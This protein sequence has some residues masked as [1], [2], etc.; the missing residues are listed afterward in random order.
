[1]EPQSFLGDLIARAR[2]AGADA[3][4]AVLFEGASLSLAQRLG[5]IEKLERSESYDLGLRVFIGKRQASVS[6][7]ERD[8]ARVGELVERAVAMAH[9]VPASR[10]AATSSSASSTLSANGFSHITG[11]PASSEASTSSRCAKGGE[12]IAMASS[13]QPSI[14]AWTLVKECGIL[15]SAAIVFALDGEA[16]ATTSKCWFASNAGRWAL[17]PKPAPLI[18]MRYFFTGPL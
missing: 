16:S 14:I 8:P 10:D 7:N 13:S 17:T 18:P 4:D 15:R 2:R 5:R 12:A 1:M 9:A 6:S 3:A 11:K